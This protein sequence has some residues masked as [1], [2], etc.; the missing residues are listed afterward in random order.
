MTQTEKIDEAFP[1]AFERIRA[2]LKE[3][4]GE[5]FAT[6]SISVLLHNDTGATLV[7][8]FYPNAHLSEVKA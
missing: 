8:H 3:V 6:A 2:T 1:N 5:D 7:N 4:Y